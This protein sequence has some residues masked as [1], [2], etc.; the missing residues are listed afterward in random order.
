MLN[1]ELAGDRNFNNY[2]P[3]SSLSTFTLTSSFR[4]ATVVTAGATF[5]LN[6]PPDVS[7]SSTSTLTLN[8]L[9][10]IMMCMQRF[11]YYLRKL[12]SFWVTNIW[13]R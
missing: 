9:N 1:K 12:R 5:M 8:E 2:G 7:W 11:E 13:K 10:I 3:C 4:L 6:E